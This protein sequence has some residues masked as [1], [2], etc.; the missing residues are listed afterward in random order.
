MSHLTFN[1]LTV[2]T[3]LKLFKKKSYSLLKTALGSEVILSSLTLAITE[4][5]LVFLSAPALSTMV[6]CDIHKIFQLLIKDET[7]L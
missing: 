4:V 3:L 1:F 5:T 6:L 7:I 2:T